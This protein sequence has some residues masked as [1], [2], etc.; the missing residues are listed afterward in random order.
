M[1]VKKLKAV[2]FV[3]ALVPLAALAGLGERGYHLLIEPASEFV[4]PVT[5][6]G[7]WASYEYTISYEKYPDGLGHKPSIEQATVKGMRGDASEFIFS[8]CYDEKNCVDKPVVLPSPAYGKSA[9]FP[10]RT[11][12]SAYIYDEDKLVTTPIFYRNAKF[13]KI[14]LY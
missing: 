9:S 12:Y 2:V 3:A 4:F 11:L 13:T 5:V 14:M 6:N 10:E 8:W 7:E 1:D